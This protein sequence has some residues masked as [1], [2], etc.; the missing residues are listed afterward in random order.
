[1]DYIGVDPTV[2]LECS[3]CQFVSRLAYRELLDCVTT[4]DVIHCDSC[5]RQM[6]HDM[7]TV[8]VVQNI[9]RRRMKQVNEAKEREFDQEME[10]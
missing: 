10:G 2:G 5:G 8:S 3:D 4:K 1:M 7:T 9:I 6:E